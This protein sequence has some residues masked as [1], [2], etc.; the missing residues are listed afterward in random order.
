MVFFAQGYRCKVVTVIAGP[1]MVGVARAILYTQLIPA[2]HAIGFFD[3]PH[4]VVAGHSQASRQPG[5][6]NASSTSTN[7]HISIQQ[8]AQR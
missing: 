7:S 3:E 6:Q 2:D 8:Q 1:Y 4:V 5:Q